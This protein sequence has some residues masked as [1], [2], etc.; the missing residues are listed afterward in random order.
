MEAINAGTL[1]C[2]QALELYGLVAGYTES[3]RQLELLRLTIAGDAHCSGYVPQVAM[4]TRR[5]RLDALRQLQRAG[6]EFNIDV[7]GIAL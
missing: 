4:G 3:D 5:V 7:A 2:D 1:L 6:V